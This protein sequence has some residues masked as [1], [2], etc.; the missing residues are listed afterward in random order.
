[1]PP[2]TGWGAWLC[3]KAGTGS[4]TGRA[5]AHTQQ[6]TGPGRV[7]LR[8]ARGVCVCWAVEQDVAGVVDRRSFVGIQLVPAVYGY[9]PPFRKW[10]VRVV[11]EGRGLI[12]RM[13][14][15]VASAL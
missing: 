4:A 15:E 14:V 6:A 12:A 13:C 8:A 9:A 7:R 5:C 10:E 1:M 11:E 3:G 2:S